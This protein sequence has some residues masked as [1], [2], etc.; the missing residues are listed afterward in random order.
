MKKLT[1]QQEKGYAETASVVRFMNMVQ[2][3]KDNLP[4]LAAELNA[5]EYYTSFDIEQERDNKP[6]EFSCSIH[7]SFGK[8]NNYHCSSYVSD[9]HDFDA[10]AN[11][12]REMHAKWQKEEDARERKREEDR[13][14]QALYEDYKAQ[15]SS[16]PL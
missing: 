5:N 11:S 2:E 14:K 7:C 15:L 3:A 13:I 16:T 9:T 4:A 8:W 1:E 6:I 12:I 10:A